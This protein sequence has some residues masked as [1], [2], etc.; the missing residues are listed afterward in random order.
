MAADLFETY[1]VTVVATMVLASIFFTSLT[2][3]IYPLAIAGVCTIASIVGTFFVRLGKN[4]NIMSA[5]YRGFIVTAVISGVLLWPIT[6]YV[7]GFNEVFQV[8]GK[9]FN[10]FNL[11]LIHI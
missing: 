2:M 8:D 7:V 4:Q 3:M 1:V 9:N 11:S 6:D 10:G 5:L